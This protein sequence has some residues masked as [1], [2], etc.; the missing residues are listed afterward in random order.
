MSSVKRKCLLHLIELQRSVV[1]ILNSG[2]RT[3]P[4]GTPV[5]Y[6]NTQP[7]DITV[8]EPVGTELM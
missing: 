7:G 1:N 3:D 5:S 4:R 8:K 6:V 2:P